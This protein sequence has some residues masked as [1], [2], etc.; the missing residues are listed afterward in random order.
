MIGL[1]NFEVKSKHS[2]SFLY[3]NMHVPAERA[4]TLLKLF[5]RRRVSA[6]LSRS[7]IG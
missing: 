4:E 5:Q 6:G 3:I 2:H 7:L 1:L